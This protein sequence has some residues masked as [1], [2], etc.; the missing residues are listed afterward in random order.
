MNIYYV[1]FYLREDF[2]PYYIGKGKGKRAYEKHG[3]I[4]V[5]KDKSKI[6]FVSQNISE[7]YALY[8]ER[9]YIK[10]FGRKDNNTGILRN[11]TDGGDGTSGYKYTK[12]A[13]LNKELS[14]F[15]NRGVFHPTQD[16]LVIE[17]Q[18]QTNNILYGVA[19]QFQRKE[20]VEDS[21]K[22]AK[23][24]NSIKATCEYCGKTGQRLG[25]MPYHFDN[26]KLNPSAIVRKCCCIICRKEITP[27]NITNH[28]KKH[29]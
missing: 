4:P 7:I 29:I 9:Y 10:W 14:N 12:E 19:N 22:R 2:T 28:F 17:K 23:E 18:K 6:I 26:C 15:K 3:K 11:L 1:Y 5:P 21:S 20:V 25:M 8:L 24:R 13:K 16:K 27:N